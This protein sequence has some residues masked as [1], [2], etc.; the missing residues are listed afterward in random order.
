MVGYSCSPVVVLRVRSLQDDEAYVAAAF[1]RHVSHCSRCADF[2]RNRGDVRGQQRQ[3]Q[4]SLCTRGQQY[5][6]DVAE[7]LYCENGKVCSVIA[8][9]R[10]QPTLV[11][12]PFHWAAVRQLLL[13]IEQG[14]PLVRNLSSDMSTTRPTLA[15]YST[16]T[17]SSPPTPTS[18]LTMLYPTS[19][20][21]LYQS[22]A[23]ARLERRCELRRIYHPDEF[24]R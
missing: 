12:T 13:A 14:M 10:N 7:Y 24:Y 4:E 1:E 21:S 23:A 6:V 9:E 18:P 5:A 3:R 16:T 11:K 19:R 15:D 2:L 22:D 8:R 17:T 20:G